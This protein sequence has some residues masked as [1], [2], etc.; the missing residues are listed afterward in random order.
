MCEDGEV[1]VYLIALDGL[2][3]DLKEVFEGMFSWV[4]MLC[5]NLHLNLI[6]K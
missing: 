6:V 5:D 3:E 1:G 2:S 4:L